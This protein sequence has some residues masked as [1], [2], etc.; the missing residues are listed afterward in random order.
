MYW[1]F[2]TKNIMYENMNS[3]LRSNIVDFIGYIDDNLQGYIGIKLELKY[4]LAVSDQD[5]NDISSINDKKTNGLYEL[6]QNEK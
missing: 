3:N 1:N 2:G 6:I 5:I 4:L